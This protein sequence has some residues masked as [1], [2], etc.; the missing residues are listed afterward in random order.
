MLGSAYAQLGQIQPALD[1]YLQALDNAPSGADVWKIQETL[2]RLYVQE[3]DSENAILHMQYA[4]NE[5]PDDQKDR[6]RAIL[7][8]LQK[9]GP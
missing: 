7:E 6:L 2:S 5:A 9:T 4:L 1:A 3:G 8:Q